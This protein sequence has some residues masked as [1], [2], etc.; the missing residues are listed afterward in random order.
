MKV[1]ME[2]RKN[3]Q[4]NQ[5]TKERNREKELMQYVGAFMNN[6][7]CKQLHKAMTRNKLDSYSQNRTHF[8]SN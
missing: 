5:S 3:K 1:N 8:K 6:Q 2:N 7:R 4:S